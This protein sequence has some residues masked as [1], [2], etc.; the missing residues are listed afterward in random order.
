MPNSD[1]YVGQDPPDCFANAVPLTVFCLGR[2]LGDCWVASVGSYN[3]AWFTQT[4]AF[5]SS[6]FFFLWFQSCSNQI[7]E[8]RQD[9]PANGNLVPT[10]AEKTRQ[11][12]PG[13]VIT[14]QVNRLY[15]TLS[16]KQSEREMLCS[17]QCAFHHSLLMRTLFDFPPSK[18]S[19]LKSD[20]IDLSIS[21][22]LMYTFVT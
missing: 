5:F 14:S 8:V 15:L 17:R 12:E 7:H 9:D 1:K 22:D 16:G 10:T 6:S 18:I 4:V 20:I 19:P 11:K 3:R 2:C 21:A 13:M